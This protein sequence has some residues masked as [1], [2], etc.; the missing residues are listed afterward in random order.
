MRNTSWG[1]FRK[2]PN[3]LILMTDQQ[4]STQ[5][6]PEGW[7][8]TYLPAMTELKNNGI[9]FN[10][11]YINASPCGTS[12]GIF[13]SGM[14]PSETGVWVIGDTLYGKSMGHMMSSMGY[15]TTLKG[16]WH[17]DDEF[18]RSVRSRP[19]DP[20]IMK[21]ETRLMEERYQFKN[22]PSPDISGGPSEPY[23]RDDSSTGLYR[24][25][26]PGA[27]RPWQ[28][29]SSEKVISGFN[30][31]GGGTV[32]NDSRVVRGPNYSADQEN[33]C[34]FLKNR[35][36]TD[37]PFFMTVSLNNPH[38]I[39]Y[40]PNRHIL[41]GYHESIVEDE[42]YKDF[43]LPPNF[44]SSLKTKPTAQQ[45]YLN[46]LNKF[47]FDASDRETS[48]NYIRFYAHLHRLSDNLFKVITDT[49]KEENL[50]EDTII[51]QVADHGEMAMAHQLRSKVYN[52]YNETIKVPFVVS[53]PKLFENNYCG[54]PVASN[55]LVSLVDVMPTLA[56]IS[57]WG[58]QELEDDHFRLYGTDISD[59]L[60]DPDLP[61]QDS[62][63]FC[64]QGRSPLAPPDQDNDNIR[65]IV[66]ENWKY[67]VYYFFT[68]REG[69]PVPQYEMY[70]L[71][72]DPYEKNNL[73]YNPTREAISQAAILHK[74]LTEKLRKSNMAPTTW[75]KIPPY[76]P[77]EDADT[78][79]Q[80]VRLVAK[81]EVNGGPWT[82]VSELNILVDGKPLDRTKWE[83]KVDSQEVVG[84]GAAAINAIDS[85]NRSH[86]H[87]QWYGVKPPEHPHYLEV[88]LQTR[89]KISQIK[90]L[91][92]QDGCP[93]GRIKDYEIQVSN[94]GETFVTLKQGVFPSTAEEQTVDI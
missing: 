92:R 13:F 69:S 2:Q 33:A 23:Q 74:K 87:T 65:A 71:K 58:K 6:F 85:R 41:A 64:H 26:P 62:V 78:K 1:P 59:T 79:F 9:T 37:K 90:Y 27:A 10:N 31:E 88:N 46:S 68:Q 75:A 47:H 84:S 49:L 17:L 51:F 4:R 7:E 32:D 5:H 60:L 55:K 93:N 35:R 91:P 20:E 83:I 24:K 12:R 34:E 30:T 42:A 73:L 52:M 76:Q 77:W 18:T 63:L 50:W 22:W 36:N 21:E 43:Q 14:Y 45:I 53:N 72:E 15:D 57:G 29:G 28:P 82:S 67:G 48:L 44:G 66:D 56:T 3:I 11:A 39:I 19:S 38:D 40:Y 94:D 86:W 81:S 70:N 54:K 89:Q 61:T 25:P 16:K 80:W 8:E